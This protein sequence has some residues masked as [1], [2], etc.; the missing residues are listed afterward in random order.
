MNQ[1]KVYVLR[2]YDWKYS[3]K[4]KIGRSS[5]LEEFN[6]KSHEERV[7]FLE[8]FSKY[9]PKVQSIIVDNLATYK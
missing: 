2:N 7:S 6:F 4:N 5:C 8:Y 3:D 9:G 1:Y